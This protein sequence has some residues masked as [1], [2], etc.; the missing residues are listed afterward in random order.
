MQ[1]YYRDHPEVGGYCYVALR[2]P[3]NEWNGFYTDYIYPLIDNLVRQFLLFG[4]VDPNKVFIMGYSHGGYGAFAIGPK[5]PDHFAAIHSSAAAP[6]DGIQPQTLRNTVFTYM[7][8]EKD[9]DYGRIDRVREFDQSIKRLR[10]DRE[11]IY[12]VNLTVIADHPHSGLPDRD[13]IAEMYPASRNPVPRELTWTMTDRVIH[14]FFWLQVENPEKGQEFN[15]ACHD[16]RVV[17]NAEKLPGGSVWLDSRLVDFKKPV[18]VE[19]QGRR[20]ARKLTP[21]L[22]LFCESMQ[23]RGDSELAFCAR[24]DLSKLKHSVGKQRAEF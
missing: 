23:R 10:G 22:R 14:D 1:I 3:N 12:P 11:D 19:W 7:V 9:T 17:V 16:N 21:D 15:V 2:A 13:K 4:D 24:V 5:M 8:G 20:T 18:T 6:A